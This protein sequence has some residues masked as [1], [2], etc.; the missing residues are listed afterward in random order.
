MH[1]VSSYPAEKDLNL[2]II[3]EIKAK[4]NLDVGYSDHSI[5]D[6][7]ILAA[8]AKGAKVV[9]KHV[10]IS[11]KMNGPDHKSSITIKSLKVWLIKFAL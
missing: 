7:A 4:F 11:R 8:I 5:D 3:D 1:C 6:D 2:N 10:T 9:E